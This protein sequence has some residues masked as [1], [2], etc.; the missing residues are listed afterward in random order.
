MSQVL[1]LNATYEPLAVITRRRAVSLIVKGRVEAIC[2]E[3]AEVRSISSILHIPAVI[4]LRRFINV[5]R[6][7]ARWSRRGVLRRDR[8]TCAYCGIQP[9]EIQ[10]GRRLARR[11]FTLDHVLPVS[12]GGRNTWGNTICAC[13][14]CNQ[15]KANRT[16]HEAAMTLAWEPKTPRVSYLVISGEIPAA[17][18]FYLEF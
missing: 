2:A 13:R 4:R 3:V 15:R 17:W 18:K 8:Y 6:R 9:G 11:D 1:L 16:P 14:A 10:G 7:R 5:P 12:R